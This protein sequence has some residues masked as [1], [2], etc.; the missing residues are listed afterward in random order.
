MRM[1]FCINCGKKIENG[2]RFC[3]SCGTP[4]GQFIDE[5]NLQAAFQETSNK[6]PYCGG[7]LKALQSTCPFCGSEDRKSVV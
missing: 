5:T 3:N 1:A 7:M 6:C 4:T 2:A